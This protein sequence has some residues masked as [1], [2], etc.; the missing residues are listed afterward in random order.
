VRAESSDIPT[1]EGDIKAWEAFV[2]QPG[3]FERWALGDAAPA[4]AAH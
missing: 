3:G 4:P 1:M 2:S